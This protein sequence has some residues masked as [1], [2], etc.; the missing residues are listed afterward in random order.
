M[1]HIKMATE[2]HFKSF[3]AIEGLF[4]KWLTTQL[5]GKIAVMEANILREDNMVIVSV[6]L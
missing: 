4:Q 3:K 1:L 2:S 6:F 5:K